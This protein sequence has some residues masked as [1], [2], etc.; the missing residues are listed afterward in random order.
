MNT[1]IWIV[2]GILVLVLIVLAAVA[3]MRRSKAQGAHAPET[4]RNG[5]A[6]AGA[7]AAGAGV[8]G[9]AAL[10]RDDKN[11]AEGRA[12]RQAGVGDRDARHHSD[13]DQ[14]TDRPGGLSAGRGA[15]TDGRDADGPG[16]HAPGQDAQDRAVHTGP[17][18]AR[19]RGADDASEA[20]TEAVPTLDQNSD[21]QYFGEDDDVRAPH[22]NAAGATVGEGDLPGGTPS[23]SSVEESGDQRGGTA[24]TQGGHDH[25]TAGTSEAGV[26]DGATRTDHERSPLQDTGDKHDATRADGQNDDGRGPGAGAAGAVGATGV[27]AGAYA[28]SNRSD[29]DAG[30]SG[31]G[32]H[33]ADHGDTERVDT[34]PGSGR[35][36][37]DRPGTDTAGCRHA[38]GDDAL[39]DDSERRPGMI[40]PAAPTE[41]GETDAGRHSVDGPLRRDRSTTDRDGLAGHDQFGDSARQ[42][43]HAASDGLSPADHS[44]SGDTTSDDALGRHQGAE[45]DVEGRGVT[46]PVPG[47]TPQRDGLA[48]DDDREFASG[49]RGTQ[50]E[51]G[52]SSASDGLA[53]TS[54][55]LGEESRGRHVGTGSGSSDAA[56]DHDARA[57]APGTATG[58]IDPQRTDDAGMVGGTPLQDQPD[59]APGEGE[60]VIGS[61]GP[62][63]AAAP[64]TPGSPGTTLGAAPQDQPMSGSTGTPAGAASTDGATSGRANPSADHSSAARPGDTTGD[65]A[66]GA[67]QKIQEIRHK[68]QE[69]AKDRWNRPGA[70]GQ[71]PGDKF[72]QLR[73]RVEGE[74]RTRMQNR[75][76]GGDGASGQ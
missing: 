40:T 66:P 33:A 38:A 59:Q 25:A 4:S 3:L 5:R 29:D 13:A 47:T 1:T 61:T 20:R 73:E 74:V 42:P 57:A 37:T 9:A 50:G 35:Q 24:T 39:G 30:R 15:E 45:R 31:T 32:R 23:G 8:A 11:A 53:P 28:A 63:H 72:G 71:T 76:R 65:N 75:K 6:A 10:G 44:A 21:A 34:A 7:G 54:P 27:A 36:V 64:P 52:R 18:A 49:A 19:D 16:A 69:Q 14:S 43:R 68:V 48:G 26:D 67:G 17:D 58:G 62:R 55:A 46:D 56:S 41:T 2:L 51:D 12:E 22:Q 60:G 70:D